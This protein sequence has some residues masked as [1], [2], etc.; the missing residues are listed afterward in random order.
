MTTPPA[1]PSPRPAI[2]WSLPVALWLLT[3]AVLLQASLAGL[4]LTGVGSAR[5]VHVIVGWILPYAAIVVAVLAG[6]A[7]RR[8]AC[9]PGMAAAIYPIPVALW[10]QEALGHVPNSIT[11]AIHVPLGVALAIH[12][13]AMA[14]LLT[15]TARRFTARPRTSATAD[16]S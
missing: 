13:T 10:I 14:V 9:P 8:R 2:G 7:H 15:T 5:M 4:F 12:L 3:A 1:P 11:T 16:R 6:V